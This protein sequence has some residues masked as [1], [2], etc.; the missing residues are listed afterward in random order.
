MIPPNG[1]AAMSDV[2]SQE[3]RAQTVGG[4]MAFNILAAAIAVPVLAL[5]SEWV[6]WRGVCGEEERLHRLARCHDSRGR[7][8]RAGHFLDPRGALGGCGPGVSGDRAAQRGVPGT[9]CRE[10]R[11]SGTVPG[12]GNRPPGAGQPVGRRWRSG[13]RRVVADR[14]GIRRRRLPM[15]GRNSGQRFGG[16]LADEAAAGK[17]RLG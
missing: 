15:P 11:V 2:I 7:A 3:R 16:A 5:L 17:R 10:Y 6:G 8:L 12:N 4:L 13:N 14:R 1:V 9:G